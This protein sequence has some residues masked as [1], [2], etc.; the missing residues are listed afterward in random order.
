MPVKRDAR[1]EDEERMSYMKQ[2]EQKIVTEDSHSHTE[3]NSYFPLN[4]MLKN[5]QN[6]FFPLLSSSSFVRSFII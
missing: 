6:I 5:I 2:T 1:D 3:L 4:C